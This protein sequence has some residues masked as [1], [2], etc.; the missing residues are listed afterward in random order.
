VDLRHGLIV[1]QPLLTA[2]LGSL[3]LNIARRIQARR[4]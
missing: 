3:I 1:L 2:L 4:A